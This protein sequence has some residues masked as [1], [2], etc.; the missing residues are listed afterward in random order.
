MAVVAMFF[1]W[2]AG[3]VVDQVGPRALMA[4]GS[5]VGIVAYVFGAL[6]HDS[7]GQIV[8][9]TALVGVTFGVA[10]PAI[11][12]VVIRG[13]S[14]DKTSIALGVNS[15][16]RTT[17]TAT[18]IAATAALITGAGLVGPFP[19]EDGF[20]RALVMGAIACAFGLAASA[21]LPGRSRASA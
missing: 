21:L 17:A 18:A 8:I 12:A 11:A 15:V 7:A 14:E 1:S 20:T 3:H 16:I 9:L 13:P 2:V 4:G 19:A 6:A 10:F 5:A